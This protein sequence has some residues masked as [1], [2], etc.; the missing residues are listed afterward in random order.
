MGTTITIATEKEAPLIAA[1]SRETFIET[2]ASYN[3]KENMEQFMAGEFAYEKLVRE[4]GTVG[5]TFFLARYNEVPAGYTFLREGSQ[6]GNKKNEA[7]EIVRIYVKAN[8]KRH[9]IGKAL[10]ENCIRLGKEK[11]KNIL[12]LAVW[13]KNNAAIDF[14]MSQGF[15]KFGTQIFM[16]G[17]DTQHDW[18]MKMD[19]P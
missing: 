1:L 11:K 4:V 14:Y 7:L 13:Q 17:K 18:Q 15:H 16:L 10:I 3:T 6:P 19:L 12:W 2:Y 9:G 5:T 8:F